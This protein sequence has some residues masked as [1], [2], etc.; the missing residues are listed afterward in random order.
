[1]ADVK[2]IEIGTPVRMANGDV[3]QVTAVKP[4]KGEVQV[5]GHSWRAAAD[6]EVVTMHE[7]NEDRAVKHIMSLELWVKTEREAMVRSA[8]TA[9]TRLRNAAE[10]IEFDI[11]RFEAGQYTPLQ[12]A[13][14]VDRELGSPASQGTTSQ[15]FSILNTIAEAEQNLAQAQVKLARICDE[16]LK[17]QQAEQTP[18]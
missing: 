1:M 13:A 6:V 8:Q 18:E 4:R 10:S 11:H 17:A 15:L 5:Y 16:G 3:A 12:F 2:T 7:F 9:I 14:Q